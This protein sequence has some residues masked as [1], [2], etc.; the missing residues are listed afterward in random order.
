VTGPQNQI[1]IKNQLTLLVSL[2][3]A[4][5]SGNGAGQRNHDKYQISLWDPWIIID[6]DNF[7]KKFNQWTYL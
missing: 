2:G 5:L 3:H 6:V 7:E 4:I 1:F